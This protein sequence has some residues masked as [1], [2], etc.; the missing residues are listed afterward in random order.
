[1][2]FWAS[3]T[4]PLSLIML[5]HLLTDPPL[6]APMITPFMCQIYFWMKKKYGFAMAL[7]SLE[8]EMSVYLLPSEIQCALLL[9]SIYYLHL[10][11]Y[12]TIDY[13]VMSISL[14]FIYV[15]WNKIF[16]CQSHTVMFLLNCS[17]NLMLDLPTSNIVLVTYIIWS[18]K[19]LSIP[20]GKAHLKK[21]PIFGPPSQVADPPPSPLLG[22]PLTYFF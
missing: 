17:W 20:L 22:T 8:R 5:C 14:S 21:T 18:I 9:A 13:I 16:P 12:L 7:R 19:I 1:M 15:M 3:W 10:Y 4:P 11:C 2:Q 6:P